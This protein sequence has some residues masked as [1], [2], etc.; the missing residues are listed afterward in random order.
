MDNNV[1]LCH[2]KSDEVFFVDHETMGGPCFKE[3]AAMLKKQHHSL[4]VL[5]QTDISRKMTSMFRKSQQKGHHNIYHFD[6]NKSICYS[7]NVAMVFCLYQ[8]FLHVLMDD[9]VELWFSS[10]DNAVVIDNPMAMMAGC[11]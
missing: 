9:G 7:E 3:S 4:P 2:S 10:A 1:E 5:K 8:Y 11:R 6:G